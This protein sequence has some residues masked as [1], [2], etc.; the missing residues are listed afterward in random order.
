[1]PV[2][3]GALGSACD[4]DD[5][6]DGGLCLG[7]PNGYCSQSCDDAECPAGG[8]CWNFG[9]AGQACLLNCD[10]ISDCRRNEGYICDGDNTCYPGDGPAPPGEGDV[11]APCQA[12]GDC[13]GG[14]RC[15]T[16]AQ[17]FPGG[18]CVIF[19]CS[20][21]SPCPGGSEC[22]QLQ[23]G[24]T[25]CLD[26]CQGAEDCR[27]GYACRPDVGACMPGCEEGGCPEG[28]IC[29]DEGLCE[30]PPCTPNSCDEGLIC[31]D[32]GRCVIDIG[33]VPGG[34]VPACDNMPD[35][36]CEG[37]EAQCGRIELFLPA[38]GQG[39]W[40]YPANGETVNN[41]Y[42]SWARRDGILLSKY[43]GALTECLS[44]NWDFGNGGEVCIGDCSEED[45]GIPGASIGRPGHPEGTHTNGYDLDMGYYQVNT[46]NNWMRPVCEHYLNGRDQYHCVGEPFAL[47]PWR[48][49][50]Y[51]GLLHHSPQLRVIGV[52]GRIGPLIDSATDQLCEA[53]FLDGPACNRRTRAI[54]YEEEDAGRGW[55]RFHHHH[56]HISLSTRRSAGLEAGFG[57]FSG[58]EACL[59]ADCFEAEWPASTA[60]K[61][62]PNMAERRFNLTTPAR[63]AITTTWTPDE[64][65]IFHEIQRLDAED[66]D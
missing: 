32:S 49:A 14:G 35:W 7:L 10:D 9:D 57:P 5:D 26:L 19:G 33:A 40:D 52:D 56:W 63:A 18:Y 64:N 13:A 8:S 53:G 23:G 37:G 47:D 59:R 24:D 29:T 38:R 44:Q 55:F 61:R 3:A 66:E 36:R 54:A 6:C 21:E 46:E 30:E 58:S 1:M 12:D 11:G 45:G 17:D 41:P 22:F 15:V 43:A 48:S 31:A 25:V 28:T 4:E 42:R 65:A 27:D 34:P 39:Y 60:L 51:L 62:L 20:E 2:Q 16:E 50:L